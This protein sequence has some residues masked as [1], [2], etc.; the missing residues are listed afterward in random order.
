[1]H[2]LLNYGAAAYSVAH[3]GLFVAMDVVMDTEV[4][5]RQRRT[6]RDHAEVIA[7]AVYGKEAEMAFA[8]PL[9]SDD[10]PVWVDPPDI[11]H[12]GSTPLPGDRRSDFSTSPA[13]YDP[14]GAEMTFMD[15]VRD[16]RPGH[17][18]LFPTWDEVLK[19]LRRLGY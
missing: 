2:S 6:A 14:T 13:T 12:R 3:S 17:G 10:F 9:S 18:Q 4:V 7:G 15:A 19:L 1:M 16:L 5:P 8:L 11:A